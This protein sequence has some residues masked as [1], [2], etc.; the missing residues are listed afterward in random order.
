MGY[1]LADNIYMWLYE[2]EEVRKSMPSDVAT[3]EESFI[4]RLRGI[5]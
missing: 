3:D 1:N 2:V 5:F 4:R